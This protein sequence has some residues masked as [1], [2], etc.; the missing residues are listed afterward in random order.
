V[1][2]ARRAVAESAQALRE[3]FT[4]TRAMEKKDSA[5]AK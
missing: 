5:F 3:A 1:D 4:G 2:A